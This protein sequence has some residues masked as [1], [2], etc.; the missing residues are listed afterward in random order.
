MLFS[1]KKPLPETVK[2]QR[3]LM[4]WL[5]IAALF[6]QQVELIWAFF[7]LTLIGIATGT[8]YSPITLF[9]RLFSKFFALPL[10]RLSTHHI[11]YYQINTAVDFIDH[12]LRIIA[13]SAALLLWYAHFETAAWVLIAFLSVFMMLSAYFGFCLS[14]LTYILL[15]RMT[16]KDQ[17]RCQAGSDEEK[18]I[19]ANC[20]LARNCFTPYKR[21]DSCHVSIS[22]CL[23]TK[24][25]TLV[26]FIGLAMSL[27]LF[28]E[29]AYLI[30][31]DIIVIMGLFFWLGY[32]INYNTDALAQSNDTNIR[33]NSQLQA[34]NQTLEDEV[35]KRTAEIE[36]LVRYDQL[37]GIYNRYWFEKIT[38][39]ALD[40]LKEGDK[41]Y[42]M[43]F[44]DLDC[45]KEVNDT[46]GHLAGDELL[47]QVSQLMQS[48]LDP[49]D[50]LA[51]LGGDEFG[52]LF[53]NKDINEAQKLSQ[54]LCEAIDA[55]RF[56]WKEH[57]FH[58][59]VSIGLVA[60]K[61][62]SVD[63]GRLFGQADAACYKVK[64]TGRNGVAVY[65]D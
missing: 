52:I 49:Q 55:Y 12:L 21:C 26:L 13:S 36:H 51:R 24:Y 37:T 1:Y 29:E 10:V 44:L 39:E 53:E 45:F 14:A 46:A 7:V 57:P 9:Y 20:T 3:L 65:E 33:L 31:I 23:G 56:E 48:L 63:L 32:Q 54:Q 6:T 15:Q 22:E 60:L 62:D 5:A 19:N 2:F 16:K 11:R 25:N 40:Q 58:I 34:Y 64:G 61:S 42:V 59:G 28:I 17:A 8:A 30:Q 27:F 4:G 41:S 50:R 35:Q 38:Q 18:Y 47:R 43:A